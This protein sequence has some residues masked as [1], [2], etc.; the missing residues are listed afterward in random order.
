VFEIISKRYLDIVQDLSISLDLRPYLEEVKQKISSGASA[1]Y[2][3]SRGEYL[4]GIIVSTLL[5]YELVDSAEVIFFDKNGD[6]DREKTYTDVLKRR[7]RHYR[8]HSGPR[9]VRRS[10]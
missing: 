2:T 8:C 7:V 4:N 10:L 5:D 6:L 3:A 1:D 9:F